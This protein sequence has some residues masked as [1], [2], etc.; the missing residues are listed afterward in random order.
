MKYVSVDYNAGNNN[1]EIMILGDTIIDNKFTMYD[2][3]FVTY[4]G[5]NYPVMFS[6]EYD[7]EVRDF[8]TLLRVG[9][10]GLKVNLD[11]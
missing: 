3:D 5:R 2:Q 1:A 4:K 8:A 10:K 9:Y 11:I 7:N 6:S